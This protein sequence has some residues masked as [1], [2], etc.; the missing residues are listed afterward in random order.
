MK[1]TTCLVSLLICVTAISL[2]SCKK[3]PAPDATYIPYVSASISG[4]S[5]TF[6]AFNDFVQLNKNTVHP[7]PYIEVK[8]SSAAGTFISVWAS[9]YTAATGIYKMDGVNY[10]GKYKADAA[11]AEA[12]SVRGTLTVTATA[13]HLTGKFNFKCTD[14]SVIDGTFD[15]PAP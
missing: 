6:N 4:S 15:C 14:S 11:T 2:Q 5:N 1:S 12:T 3:K 13:P 7:Y 9:A 8:G 10:G